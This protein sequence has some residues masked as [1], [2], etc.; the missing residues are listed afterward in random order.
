MLRVSEQ[1]PIR[2]RTC[3]TQCKYTIWTLLVWAPRIYPSI[4]VIPWIR[5][6]EQQWAQRGST[7]LLCRPRFESE[8]TEVA[9][10]IALPNF[11][12]L[13][14]RNGRENPFWIWQG[15]DLKFVW[16]PALADHIAS[17][18]GIKWLP[19][20]GTAQYP[21]YRNS[22]HNRCVISVHTMARAMHC[23][24]FVQT[25]GMLRVIRFSLCP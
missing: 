15:L 21:Q 20:D 7:G 16:R 22:I 9:V 13:S 2:N 14:S 5:L 23:I 1:A 18:L 4:S 24:K 6:P 11:Q 10:I 3:R 8:S 17:Y 12:P 19:C 25:M